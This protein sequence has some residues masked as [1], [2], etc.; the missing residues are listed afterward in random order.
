M[1]NYLK[2]LRDEWNTIPASE[3]VGPVPPAKDNEVL[4]QFQRM[5]T[6]NHA[7]AKRRCIVLE[8]MLRQPV[9]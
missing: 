1:Q 6:E 3:R 2:N 9:H 7:E 5:N 8:R 4:A